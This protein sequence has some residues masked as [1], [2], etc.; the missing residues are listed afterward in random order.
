MINQTN[1]NLQ[2]Q[3]DPQLVY[4][5]NTGTASLPFD[6]ESE[7]HKYSKIFIT[8]EFDAFKIVS[9]C[10][11]SNRD[12]K[13]L[14]ETKDGDKKLLFTSYIHS[15]C[16]NCCEQ[17]V[18]GELCCGYACC[19]TIIF[20]MDYRRNGQPF[21]TQGFNLTK[22]CHCCDVLLCPQLC[23]IVCAGRKLYLRENI[24]PDS[25]DI[26]IGRPK[27]KTETN[28]CSCSCSDKFAEYKNENKV[29]G[30]TVR[31]S[32]CDICKNNCLSYCLTCG[33][34]TC[35]AAGLDFEISIEDPNGL[36]TGN[37]L[38]YSGC[39][40]KKVEGK[41][42]HFPRSYMEIN[43]PLNCTSEEKFQIIADTIHLDLMNKFL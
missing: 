2:Q 12:Y 26:T 7:L 29:K 30:Y 32:C 35:C 42:C 43:M 16:C 31:A 15:D 24:D 17:C 5:V 11:S 33:V 6:V 23:C 19:N 28:A 39:C 10:D 14:G 37:I 38:I 1:M 21:Y 41:M 36:K 25:P 9:C 18:I 40:S 20:Q 27:G 22:G 3:P 4:H 13:I 8:K 34:C